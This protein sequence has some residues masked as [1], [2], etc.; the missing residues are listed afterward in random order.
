MKTLV[1]RG[2]D[3]PRPFGTPRR[4]GALLG[5]KSVVENAR[6]TILGWPARAAVPETE[7]VRNIPAETLSPGTVAS[8]MTLLLS[9]NVVR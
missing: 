3:R 6:L 8:S 5:T 4:I 7:Q 9:L 1:V 2:M